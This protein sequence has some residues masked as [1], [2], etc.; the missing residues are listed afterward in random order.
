MGAN[1][2]P[3]LKVDAADSGQ[4][5]D[6]LLAKAYPRFSRAYLQRV[7]KEGRVKWAG[8]AFTVPSYRVQ[9]GERFEV[10]DLDVKPT[11]S[12]SAQQALKEA[13]AVSPLTPKILAEDE[14]LLVIDKPAGLVVHPAPS[15]QGMTLIDWLRE[16]LGGKIIDL[17]ADQQR[18][19]LV[20]RLDKDTSGVLLIAKNVVAQTALSRQFQDRSI[21]KTYAA[22]VEGVLSSS[23]GTISAPVARSRKSPSRMAVSNYGRPSETRFSVVKPYKE[24]SQ[25]SLEPKTGRTHQI[26]VHMAAVGHP[27]VGDMTYGSQARWKETFGIARPLLHAERIELTHP[28]TQERVAFT[29]PWPEDFKQAKKR[30]AAAFR[31]L[32]IGLTLTA[33]AHLACA[34]E[35]ADQA[36]P[37]AKKVHHTSTASSSASSSS[38]SIHALK[39]QVASLQKSL[40]SLEQNLTQLQQAVSG[41]QASVQDLNAEQRFRDLDHAIAELNA[42]SVTSNTSTEETRT[43]VLDV[44]RRVKSQQELL[45]Q[46]RDQVDRLTREV[47]QRRSQYE[48]TQ[49]PPTTGA[50]PG[51]AVEA[52]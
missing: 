50:A 5:L 46:L 12:W 31:L 22:F 6:V 51:G 2:M 28:Q 24:V 25:V 18:L 39:K 23:T 20:H 15:H 47:I 34:E 3:V 11:V 17:F 52:H 21:Q 48:E 19:G 32:F 33:A 4:R 44:S 38:A 49:P 1:A 30:F 26:R 42:K 27:I 45:D 7:L 8:H 35:E 37:P 16:H 41:V 10:P 14:A 9:A 40:D 13:G 43:Q 29:A 36:P